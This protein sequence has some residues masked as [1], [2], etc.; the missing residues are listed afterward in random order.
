MKKSILLA[1]LIVFCN[2]I[3]AQKKVTTEGITGA[4]H[5]KYLGKIVFSSD[6]DPTLKKS[7]EIEA[8]FKNEFDF[9]ADSS[10]YFR[11]YFDNS[12][13]NYLKPLVKGKVGSDINNYA[14]GFNFYIDNV[15][16]DKL[17]KT[18]DK[19][20][21]DEQK[22]TW[23]TFR[24]AFKKKEISIY[25]GEPQFKEI[26]DTYS[27]LLSKGKHTIKVEIYPVFINPEGGDSIKGSVIA[28]GE[29]SLNV[30]NSV[31]NADDDNLCLTKNVMNDP[32]LIKNIALAL[33]KGNNNYKISPNDVRILSNSWKT[34][35]NQYSGLIERRTIEVLFGYKKL[36]DNKCYRS[37]FTFYQE[38]IGSKFSNDL[39]YKYEGSIGLQ[40]GEINCKCLNQ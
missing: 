37:N 7:N 23:T 39:L 31:F 30:K 24:G 9:T 20:F 2:N 29:F 32:G 12:I 14:M 18:T 36:S 38:F 10:I 5:Q 4:T 28:S 40:M 21:P 33:S 19:E 15:L 13:Y 35:R 8:N 6:F 25:F 26:L 1:L 17:Q 27:D 34:E 16:L 11:A 22:K 3:N